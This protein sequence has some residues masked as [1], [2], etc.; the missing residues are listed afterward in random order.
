MKNFYLLYGNDKSILNKEINDLKNK[1]SITDNDVVYYDINDVYNIVDE[2]E[3][4][5]KG[6]L[7]MKVDL[8]VIRNA[9]LSDMVIAV[10]LEDG[11]GV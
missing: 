4:V 6:M 7:I 8:E 10:G 11:R 1:L 2:G 3:C 5:T 9:D